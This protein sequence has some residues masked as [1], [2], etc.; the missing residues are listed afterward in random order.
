MSVRQKGMTLKDIELSHKIR[1]QLASKKIKTDDIVL[2]AC[3][4]IGYGSFIM[5]NDSDCIAIDAFDIDKQAIVDARNN[6]SHPK[7]SYH[8]TDLQRADLPRERYDF[9]T[10]FEAVE[11]LQSPLWSLS[12]LMLS[13]QYGATLLMS[14]PCIEWDATRFPEHVKHYTLDEMCNMLEDVGLFVSKVRYQRKFNPV[15]TN[16]GGDYMI[17]EATK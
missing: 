14:T 4:G 2:D 15:M 6:Y 8:I 13:M 12:E 11:H 9:V 17:I 3:C 10:F 1:Y 7:I 5:A 16:K